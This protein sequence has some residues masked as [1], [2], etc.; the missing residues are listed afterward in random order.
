MAVGSETAINTPTA[1][2]LGGLFGGPGLSRYDVFGQSSKSQ[3]RSDTDVAF[4][5]KCRNDGAGLV[6]HTL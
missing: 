6:Q 4:T 1:R 2:G 5:E 3:H